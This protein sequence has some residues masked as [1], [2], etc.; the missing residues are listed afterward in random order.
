MQGMSEREYAAH[1]GLSLGPIQKAKASGRLVL[2]A[3]GSIDAYRAAATDPPKSKPVKS[4]SPQERLKPVP[5]TAVWL[6]DG[7]SIMNHLLVHEDDAE[8]V[9]HLRECCVETEF[10]LPTWRVGRIANMSLT[11][12]SGR[13]PTRAFRPVHGSPTLSNAA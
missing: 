4:A 9:E 13:R 5:E 1:A 11:R 12:P 2:H 6:G 10:R 3:D 8:V 7:S